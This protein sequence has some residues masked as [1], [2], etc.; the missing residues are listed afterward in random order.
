MTGELD[1]R[2]AIVTGGAQGIGRAVALKLTEWGADVVVADVDLDGAR[3]TASMARDGRAVALQADVACETSVN[4]LYGFVDDRFGKIDIVVSNAGIFMAKSVLDISL[5]EWDRIMAVNLR[6]TF[7]IGREA[8]RRM[9]PRRT[10][11][12]VNLGSLSGKTG[13][14]AAGAHYAASK[15]GVMC[16][17]KSL[18]A[19]AAAYKINVNA[20]CPGF[21]ETSMTAAWGRE[22]NERLASGL[23][24]KA[25]GQPED[26]AEA[27]AF[28]ACDRAAYITGE[29]I[30]VNGGVL[31]D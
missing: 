1:G 2:A 16:F 24:W 4:E 5:D 20:V 9:K 14:V 15:A 23:P 26:V 10:G 7:L 19:E 12:I 3:Q 31:M 17:T 29:I 25:Y 27:V 30:D 6:G 28:L 22:A 21:I 11:K 18:A 13:G 8:L